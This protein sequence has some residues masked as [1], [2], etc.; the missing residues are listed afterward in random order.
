MS[1]ERGRHQ[2]AE[3]IPGRIR[4]IYAWRKHAPRVPFLSV[5][6]SGGVTTRIDW[7]ASFSLFFSF[8]TAPRSPHRLCCATRTDGLSRAN[9]ATARPSS[10]PA[11]W[12][13]K[14]L[15]GRN[16]PTSPTLV[17]PSI[18]TWATREAVSTYRPPS[19]TQDFRFLSKA[20]IQGR[21]RRVRRSPTAQAPQI[22]GPWQTRIVWCRNKQPESEPVGPL[23]TNQA[24][25]S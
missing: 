20:P 12:T 10:L 5:V 25:L 2:A 1:K 3:L 15:L 18:G 19:L 8:Q 21:N 4:D 11:Y 13:G 9:R 16:R 23:F 14:A 7:A 6:A 24:E 17:H 22:C